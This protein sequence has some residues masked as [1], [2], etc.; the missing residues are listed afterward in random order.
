[1][2]LPR[3]VFLMPLLFLAWPGHTAEPAA[4]DPLGGNPY[5]V[6]FYTGKIFPTP[7]EVTYSDQFAPLD[8]V[9]IVL[10]KGIAR[11]D[12]RLRLLT[13]RLE[14]HGAVVHFAASLPDAGPPPKTII[15][16]GDTDAGQGLPQGKS[17]PDKPEGYLL[18]GSNQNGK[19]LF[20]LKGHDFHG[21][22][23]AIT[24]LDQ[25]VHCHQG[26]PQARCA[27]VIDYPDAPGKRGYTAF[28]DDDRASAAWFA[29]NCLRA[30]AVLYRQLRVPSDWRGPIK[31][32]ERFSAWQDR[33]KRIGGLLNPLRITW[34]DAL[35]PLSNAKTADQVR[36]KSEEDFGLVVAAGMA[37]AEAGG[38]LCLLYD[39]FRFPMHPD[40]VRDF[41]TAR[42]SDVHFLNKVY[43]AVAAKHPDFKIL[44]CPPFYWGPASDASA[45]YGESRDEYLA[46]IGKRLPKAIEIFWTGPR[47]KSNKV[48]PQDMQWI[49]GLIQRKPV[50]WQ[51]TAGCYHG[52]LFYVYPTDPM[53]AW[54]DWYGEDFFEQLTL[55]TYNGDDPYTALTLCDAMW[56]RKAYD[57]AASAVE[58]GKKLA[59]PEAYPKLN[60][61][62]KALEVLDAYGWFTPTALA[63]KNVEQVRKLTEELDRIYAAAPGSLKSRWL[64]LEM[65][66]GYRKKYLASLLKNPQLK[67]LTAVD[68]LVRALA[69]K[70]AG[71]SADRGHII[72]TPNDFRAG[73]QARHYAWKGAD[74]RYVLWING[75]RSKAP[76]MEAAFSLKQPP[77][78]DFDLIIAGL[79]HNATPAC[80]VQI[81]ANG[82]TVFEGPNPFVAERWTTHTFRVRG[83]F[84]RDNVNTL[85]IVNLED[86]D[87][88]TGAPWFMISYAVVRPAG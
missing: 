5:A 18:H 62:C 28:R 17:V 13:E 44:F 31:D 85:R 36:S 16:I 48:T 73:R 63:A 11:D 77:T 41:G 9:G 19:Y 54:R 75:A 56:N 51:N 24:A 8:T 22:L 12:A 14:R 26:R 55:H 29:V 10:G 42:Q 38:N 78:G 21:L 74:R 52:D 71:A 23:W 68:D 3:I 27:T 65:Y 32:K 83:D 79:D 15:L 35:L 7:Q 81:L 66:V 87:S 58:A 25:L 76:A 86:S 59:G 72:L 47:V 40:D 84:L 67:E 69:A 53:S 2:V 45:A 80:R 34:Y 30:N 49:T 39:D 20:I 33:I 60:E 6:P 37:L 61:V 64:P 43:S 57:P 82:K 4:A 88:M 50:Y 1:M 46:A 70:E